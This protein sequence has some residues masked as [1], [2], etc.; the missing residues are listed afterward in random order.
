MSLTTGKF[1]SRTSQV[2]NQG[3]PAK[4]ASLENGRWSGC[5]GWHIFVLKLV[6]WAC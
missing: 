4:P 1:C 5:D 2:T 6:D 3:E